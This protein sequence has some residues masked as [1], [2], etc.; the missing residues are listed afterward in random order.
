ME[1]RGAEG[2]SSPAMKHWED[3]AWQIQDDTEQVLLGRVKWLRETTGA[4]NLCIAGGVGLNC[5]ANGKLA[6]EGGFENVWIQPAAGDDG[7]AIGCAYYGHLAVL[8][9]PRNSV[10]KH[11]FLGRPYSTRGQGRV[12]M[13]GRAVTALLS[14]ICKETAKILADGNAIGCQ[15]RPDYLRA[16]ATAASCRSARRR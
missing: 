16:L 10:I 1:T 4:K 5:V 11:A 13:A 8:K 9:Q 12:N 3:L 14:H 7:I 6:R 15:G 2:E